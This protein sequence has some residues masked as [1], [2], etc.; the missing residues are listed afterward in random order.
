MISI[1]VLLILQ[2]F[3]RFREV[4]V[5]ASVGDTIK[6]YCLC[7]RSGTPIVRMLAGFVQL[8]RTRPPA[9]YQ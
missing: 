3:Q 6:Y 5:L 1:I 9:A 2:L 7:K 8:P 4:C